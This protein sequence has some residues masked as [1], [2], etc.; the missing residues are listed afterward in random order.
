M[1]GLGGAYTGAVSEPANVW[2][3]PAVTAL[4]EE[5]GGF[6]LSYRRQ[7]DLDELGEIDAS[8]RHRWRHG[9]TVGA[10]FARFGES[11]LYLETRGT[12]AAAKALRDVYAIGIGVRYARTEFGDNE[13]AFAG[14]SLDLG[15]AGRPVSDILAAFAVR[16]ITLDGLYDNDDQNAGVISDASVAWSAP[17]DIVIAGVWS[18]EEGADSR[19]GLGQRLQ[20][21]SGAEFVSG[22]RFD[23]VR[24][25]L[26]ARLTHRGGTFDY[27]YQSHPD[28]GGTHTI[29]IGWQW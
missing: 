6:G 28:L 21:A 20:I 11:G 5:R 16:G 23:P 14:A 8:M 7:Y 9:L 15:I 1:V 26:G 29:G 13:M 19:F 12:V 4:A 3:N 2:F 27:I 17:P 22:L 25:T 10:G 18:K 24:Y